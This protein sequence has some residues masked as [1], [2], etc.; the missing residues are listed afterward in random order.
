MKILQV[1]K[2]FYPPIKGGIESHLN[3]LTNGLRNSGVDVEV[4]VSS[5][6]NRFEEDKYEGIRIIKVPQLGR[7]YSAPLTPTFHRYLKRYGNN[8]DIIHFHHPNPTAELSYFL[9][10]LNKK[11]NC[12]L[13]Q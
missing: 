9:T 12:H 4:L 13:S 10:N 8:A 6:S 11:I 1:Y 5:T 2:D 7:F 3:L